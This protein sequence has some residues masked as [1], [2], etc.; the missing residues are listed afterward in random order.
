[1]WALHPCRIQE[2]QPAPR[3]TVF[4][5]VCLV[6][7]AVGRAFTSWIAMPCVAHLTFFR[8][9]ASDAGGDGLDAAAVEARLW[10]EIKASRSGAEHLRVVGVMGNGDNAYVFKVRVCGVSRLRRRRC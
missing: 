1:V 2:T 7:L 4:L 6:E 8:V 10:A 9:L 3:L 5:G